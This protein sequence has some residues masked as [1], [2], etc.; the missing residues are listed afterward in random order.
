MP[1][2]F[3]TQKKITDAI[4]KLVAP[5]EPNS[6]SGQKI[7]PLVF[8]FS[9]PLGTRPQ[10]MVKESAFLIR[11]K[12]PS[13][14]VLSGPD[15]P[16]SF[17]GPVVCCLTGP[18][19]LLDEDITS[20]IFAGLMRE[21]RSF[22]NPPQT[23]WIIGQTLPL[24]RTFPPL[25]QLLHHRLVRT[26]LLSSH[27]LEETTK[28]LQAM[29]PDISQSYIHRFYHHT[30]GCPMAIPTEGSSFDMTEIL[31]RAVREIYEHIPGL[32]LDLHSF[33][34]LL[35]PRNIPPEGLDP[36]LTRE[37]LN[38]SISNGQMDRIFESFLLSGLLHPR[39][40]YMPDN[41]NCSF[42]PGYWSD[43]A[44]R[45]VFDSWLRNNCSPLY[46]QLH[47]ICC[48]HNLAQL[49]SPGCSPHLAT[50][51]LAE[52]IYHHLLPIHLTR[53]GHEA[54]T[55][56]RQIIHNHPD[57]APLLG[58]LPHV[59][60]RDKELAYLV[61]LATIDQISQLLPPPARPTSYSS[62]V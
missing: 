55:L 48:Q 28:L 62:L 33:A 19:P 52:A 34:R 8:A 26:F 51:Y 47:S 36:K 46:S 11:Y 21:E 17:R 15:R 31:Y 16:P 38:G 23:M 42:P 25:N 27:S 43:S 22:P 7:P 10:D 1:S 14:T 50:L 60:G 39:G 56:V 45:R 35:T 3:E 32:P 12:D 4:N 9:G 37:L 44:T 41:Q 18:A 30:F 57:L 61:P 54:I 40:D 24:F 53:R 20:A 6:N 5:E 2:P 59:I 58:Q 49:T 29:R 13:I